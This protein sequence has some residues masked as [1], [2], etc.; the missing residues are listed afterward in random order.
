MAY[1]DWLPVY[2]GVDGTIFASASFGIAA[3]SRQ[4]E[5]KRR[6]NA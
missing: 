5:G 2:R 6:R 1:R 4:L 3:P